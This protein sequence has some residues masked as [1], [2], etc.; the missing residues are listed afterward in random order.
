MPSSRTRT[1]VGTGPRRASGRDEPHSGPPVV[2]V[3][4]AAA[5]VIC[6][7]LVVATAAWLGAEW[8]REPS[9][10]L[11]IGIWIVLLGALLV[12]YAG[13]RRADLARRRTGE[14]SSPERLE[15][16][17]WAR[18]ILSWPIS[19][20]QRLGVKEERLR[21]LEDQCCARL[22]RF[23]PAATPLRIGVGLSHDLLDALVSTSGDLAVTWVRAE[24]TGDDRE[25]CGDL[26]L[27]ALVRRGEFGPL[28]IA[29]P[30]SPGRDA[31]WHD[32]SLPRPL[33]YASIFSARVDPGRVSVHDA[34]E[35]GRGDAPVLRA[36]IEAAA[37]LGRTPARLSL[38]DRL[39]GRAPRIARPGHT[40]ATGDDA[41][42]R[43]AEPLDRG[44]DVRASLA[45][46]A[47]RAVGAWLASTPTPVDVPTRRSGIE[48]AAA[49]LGDEPEALLRL[50]AV[51]FAA[52]DDAG[53]F[54]ALQR[55]DRLIR[56]AR[57][58]PSTDQFAFLESEVKHGLHDPMTLGRV[59]AGI[60]LIAAT[61][62][63]EHLPH[64][65]DDLMEDLRF[66]EWLVGRD[67]DRALLL[68]AFRMLERAR[69]A[70]PRRSAA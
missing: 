61:R 16:R 47:A 26:G 32:W 67:Q 54:D 6:S 14:V 52:H 9:C 65:R 68:D 18:S 24:R 10:G 59:A 37:A 28:T 33:S 39:L 1:D 5:Y 8:L 7:T 41:L 29:V 50:T 55:A 34:D 64:L 23:R 58:E 31:P 53:A 25:E 63:A 19:G 2:L 42:L 49:I 21:V 44:V 27:D 13:R 15:W 40:W 22:D 43:L 56:A 70:K 35:L 69:T 62:P 36:L 30:E 3:P 60:C 38:A 11:P 4:P 57:P 48:A 66:A 17:R 46:P 12:E 20:A 45:R 51:R